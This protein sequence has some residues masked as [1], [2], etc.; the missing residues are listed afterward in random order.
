MKKCCLLLFL[1]LTVMIAGC[2]SNESQEITY[3]P[4]TYD[5]VS[6][7]ES[8]QDQLTT[9]IHGYCLALEHHSYAEL[10]SYADEELPLCRNETAFDDYTIGLSSV[11]VHSMDFDHLLKNGDDYL[12]KINYTLVFEGS[13]IDLDGNSMAPCTMELTDLFTLSLTDDQYLISSVQ[14]YGEG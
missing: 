1:L 14:E 9:V 2:R 13:F 3:P 11:T 8:L 4:I 10:Q 7:D 5:P 12:L 6:V